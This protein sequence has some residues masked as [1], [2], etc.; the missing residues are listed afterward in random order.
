MVRARG[1]EPPVLS[2]PDAK[3]GASAIPPRA[4][5]RKTWLPQDQSSSGNGTPNPG[6]GRGRGRLER[7]EIRIKRKIKIKIKQEGLPDL[8]GEDAGAPRAAGDY[9][10]VSGPGPSLLTIPAGLPTDSP[11]AANS[12]CALRD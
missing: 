12:V 2:E 1:L 10:K 3:S 4:R 11:P 6:R 7:G 9:F 8:S 5:P